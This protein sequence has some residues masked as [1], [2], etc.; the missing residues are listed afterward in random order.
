MRNIDFIQIPHKLNYPPTLRGSM[1][2][3]HS[4]AI[5]QF[6]TTYTGGYVQRKQIVHILNCIS[7]MYMSGDA[8]PTLWDIQKPCEHYIDVDDDEILADVLG[9]VFIESE[10]S[11]D[12]RNA[13]LQ[14]NSDVINTSTIVSSVQTE[15]KVPVKATIPDSTDFNYT[16][17]ATEPLNNVVINPSDK[18]DLYI[19]SPIVPQFDV[20]S[21]WK[22]GYVDGQMYTV[23]T[24]LPIIPT[25]QNEISITTNVDMMT[26]KDLRNLFPA[27]FIQTRAAIMYEPH[28]GMTLDP[29]VGLI[30]PIEGFT[31]S[32]VAENIIQYPHLFKLLRD[33]DGELK[34][35]Y[36]SIEI[37]GELHKVM[38]IWDTLPEAKIIPYNK[39]FVKE[40]VVRRYLLERDIKHIQHRYSMYGTLDPF[41]TLFTTIDDYIHMGYIDPVEIA[42]KCV[43]S[44]I[45]Y[46]Q[47]RNPV[48][49]R[50]LS[51]G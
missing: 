41:L 49:R 36:S 39:D 21:P 33:V 23:Y 17:T 22:F 10:K 46:K 35:F 1:S 37:D 29:I 25:K 51:N 11:L 32:Q 24:S 43:K 4:N 14:I 20:K 38:D 48:L 5:S 47:S 28:P 45:S 6:L 40:Y 2:T 30:L 18:S 34:S 9:D 3:A 31:E 15:V 19:Q 12:W 16:T 26:E 8:F 7:Y 50:L 13:D 27:N 42:R 44:R